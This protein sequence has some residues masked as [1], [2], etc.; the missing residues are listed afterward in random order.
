M[1]VVPD[2]IGEVCPYRG[3]EPFGSAD[4]D[5]FHGRGAVVDGL[6]AA[7]GRRGVLL[8]G[9][10]GSGKSSVVH[11]GLLPGVDGQV[12]AVRPGNS[13]VAELEKAGLADAVGYGLGPALEWHLAPL[14]GGARLLL[15]I[16]QFEEMLTAGDQWEVLDALTT[17]I[18]GTAPVTVLLVMRNDFYAR[19]A[20]QAPDLFTALEPGVVN[21]PATVSRAD[22]HAMITGPAARAGCGLEAGLADRIVADAAPAQGGDRHGQASVSVLPLLQLT[23][24][25]L[26]HLHHGGLLTHRAFEQ[27]GGVAGSLARL[28]D[29]V[30]QSLPEPQRAIA[31]RILT[32]LILPA[33]LTRHI[34]A[35]RRRMPLDDLRELAADPASRDPAEVETVLRALTAPVPLVSTR[36]VDGAPPVAE[37]IHD[38]VIDGWPALRDWVLV[39]RQFHDW[40]RRAEEQRHQWAG[41]G[42]PA[43]LPRGGEL[44]EGLEWS[45]RRTLP[46]DVGAFVAA[47]ERAARSR[48]RRSRAAAGVM[49]VLLVLAVV[50]AGVASW[51]WR[52][53]VTAQRQAL[54]RQL[55]AQSQLTGTGDVE[56]SALLALHGYRAAPTEQA[57]ARLYDADSGLRSLRRILTGGFDRMTA[58][59]VSADGRRAAAGGDDGVRIWDAGTGEL[60]TTLAV[61]DRLAVYALAFSPDGT[62][63]AGGSQGGDVLLWH[64]ATGAPGPILPGDGNAMLDVRFSPDGG[65]LTGVSREGTVRSWAMPSG[66]PSGKPRRNAAGRLHDVSAIRLS[67]DGRSIATSDAGGVVLWDTTGRRSRSIDAAGGH[68]LAMAFS[69]DG[70]NL[71]TMSGKGVIELWR[72]ADGAA[73]TTSLGRGDSVLAMA[74]GPDGTA[75]ATVG[76]DGTVRIRE[77]GGAA[78]RTIPATEQPAALRFSPDGRTVSAAVLD[79]EAVDALDLD[80]IAAVVFPQQAARDLTEVAFGADGTVATAGIQF[81]RVQSWDAVSG[82]ATTSAP[83]RGLCRGD[84]SWVEP[85]GVEDQ[86][87]LWRAGTCWTRG[88]RVR[89]DVGETVTSL[90]VS[91]DGTILA[92]GTRAGSIALLDAGSGAPLAALATPDAP[93]TA[94]AFGPDGRTLAGGD[95]DGDVLLWDTRG[96]TVRAILAGDQPVAALAFGPDGRILASGGGNGDVRLWDAGTGMRRGGLTGTGGPVRALAFSP[97]G[98][99]LAGAEQTIRLWPIPVT[100]ED[101]VAHIC[102]VI[103]NDLSP[104]QFAR[105]LPGQ[106]ATA[107]CA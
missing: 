93:V 33:D 73:V 86:V 53:A 37:L 39:D 1:S 16:D 43:Y 96:R 36:A 71:A 41:S 97:D 25:R 42:D 91:P 72:V 50:L 92:A 7:L 75:L 44:V 46:R 83:A 26:W 62:M 47:G 95:T 6:R 31:R 55:A 90:A 79:E 27:I 67:P 81:L 28:C 49:A 54:S 101:A 78:E 84:R 15:V 34:P 80:P 106:P 3:L 65:T 102:A 10:S 19:L 24:L 56:L 69:P 20:E 58:V 45:R 85:G 48:L 60:L 13:L 63:L 30:Y 70:A 77:V 38:A 88:T 66:K 57:L 104:E 94:L 68:V 89:A 82:K 23:L 74:F 40:L 64:V 107:A 4:A 9:P 61:V 100:P 51:Q 22:L 52:E 99:T 29:E 5:W 35:V 11:A 59:A 76:D 8:L 17:V 87:N 32:A 2:G 21:I 105:Y 18:R 12:M 98:R 103:G 14:P